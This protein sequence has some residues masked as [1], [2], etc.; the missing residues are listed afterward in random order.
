MFLNER[1]ARF[2]FQFF[3][4]LMNVDDKWKQPGISKRFSLFKTLKTEA[5]SVLLCVHKYIKTEPR[6]VKVDDMNKK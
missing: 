4:K 1:I 5:I 2:G 3:W 6:Q